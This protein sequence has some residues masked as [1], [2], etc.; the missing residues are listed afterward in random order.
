MMSTLSILS[1]FG[2]Y[3]QI[4]FKSKQHTQKKQLA[5]YQMPHWLIVKKASHAAYF[6]L[7]CFLMIHTSPFMLLPSQFAN[8]HG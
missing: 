5:Y 2:K 1:L 7:N 8:Y 6:S 4:H 3:F